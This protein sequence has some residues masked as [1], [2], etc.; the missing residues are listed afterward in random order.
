MQPTLN[1]YSCLPISL[2]AGL[3]NPLPRLTARI[4]IG[5]VSAILFAVAE[6]AAL[7]TVAIAAGQESILTQ[8]LVG[9]Q[10]R[11]NLALFVFELTVFHSFLPVAR[12]LFNVEEETSRATDGLKSL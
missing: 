12:L 5:T 4:F 10:E 11:F 1:I 3:S 2:T 9:N 6:E 7:D 8:R